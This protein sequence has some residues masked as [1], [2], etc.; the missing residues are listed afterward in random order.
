MAY[1]LITISSSSLLVNYL[2]YCFVINS[3]RFPD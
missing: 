2:M 3:K 1:P